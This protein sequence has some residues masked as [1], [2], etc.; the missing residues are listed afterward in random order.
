MRFD[1]E[2]SN[3]PG[4]D[5][6]VLSQ[7]ARSWADRKHCDSRATRLLWPNAVFAFYVSC[8]CGTCPWLDLCTS[9]HGRVTHIDIASD[10]TFSIDSSE[11]KKK[12]SARRLNA[13]RSLRYTVP[14]PVVLLIYRTMSYRYKYAIPGTWYMSY[15]YKCLV[16]RC[17]NKI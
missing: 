7:R 9:E 10:R 13:P 8:D 3:P 17:C 15:R 12:V 1:D 4:R 14:V 16:H 5:K 11:A 6:V 2:D